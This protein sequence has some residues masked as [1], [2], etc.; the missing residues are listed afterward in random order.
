MYTDSLIVHVKT[1]IAIDID[2]YIMIFTKILQK[3]LK[4]DLTLQFMK[5]IDCC[6]W[7]RIKE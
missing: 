4:Q 7:E 6:L 1:D 2:I 3:M 5:Q